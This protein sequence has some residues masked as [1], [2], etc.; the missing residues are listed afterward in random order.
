[1][2]FQITTLL[3]SLLF[4][5]KS[6]NLTIKYSIKLSHLLGISRLAIG[7]LFISLVTTLPEITI[8]IMASASGNGLLSVGNLL[9]SG[10]VNI[11]LVFGVILLLANISI[12]KED[13]KEIV[14]SISV[15]S[16]IVLFLLFLGELDIIFGLVCII[17]FVLFFHSVY[18]SNYHLKTKTKRYTGLKTVE[19]VKTLFFAF[20]SIMIVV[21]SAKFLTDSAVAISQILN[22]P[23]ALIGASII[24]IGTSV[25]ELS[26]AIV[27]IRKKNYSMAIGD[28]MGATAIDMTL[29][30]G[31]T[32][33]FGTVLMGPVA[34]FLIA[35]L[36]FSGMA[37]L[38][39]T[40]KIKCRRIDGIILI[41]IFILFLI[42]LIN[43]Q[44]FFI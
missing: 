35:F 32:S 40:A 30:M 1:M 23:E 7:F 28:V 42:G 17:V 18:K 44:L 24:A 4:L 8:G 29:V 16:I 9:G 36:L 34:N 15:V 6:S 31:I 14:R 12:R 27:A 41:S 13:Y 20:F 26:I 25:P 39:L 11:S 38:F 19:T 2:I 10:I 33:L 43:Y 37:L 22:V 21:I 3:I 5:V